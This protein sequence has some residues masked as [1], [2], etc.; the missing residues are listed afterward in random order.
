M[1][2]AASECLPGAGGECLGREREEIGSC[3]YVNPFPQEHPRHRAEGE[4]E[5]PGEEEQYPEVG[6]GN[7]WGL[8]GHQP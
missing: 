7:L 3:V 5:T 2:P 4:G 6:G 8:C 1:T